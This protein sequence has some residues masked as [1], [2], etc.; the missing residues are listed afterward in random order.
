M[1]EE[2]HDS[3]DSEW[4]ER[5]GIIACKRCE[6]SHEIFIFSCI[7]YN[8]VDIIMFILGCSSTHN[9][10]SR[11]DLSKKVQFKSMKVHIVTTKKTMIFECVTLIIYMNEK[12]TS[13]PLSSFNWVN[14]FR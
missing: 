6:L 10:E 5:R 7:Y 4:W 12:I 1:Q 8:S 3:D 2:P 13:K 11:R 9:F 14:F